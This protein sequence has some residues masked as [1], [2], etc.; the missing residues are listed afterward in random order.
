[1]KVGGRRE[2]IVPP[3]DGYGT[4]GSPPNIT[5]NEELIFVVD[6][7]AASKTPVAATSGAATTT[8]AATATTS[9][10]ASIPASTEPTA[11]PTAA[12]S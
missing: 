11:T 9:P 2:I 6:V 3:I 7:L 4:A 1:M 5:G 12:S 8:P 10:A